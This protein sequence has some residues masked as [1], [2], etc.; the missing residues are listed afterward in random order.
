M[1]TSA[2]A[3]RSIQ[4]SR[5]ANNQFIMQRAIS[6]FT[7]LYPV[8]TIAVSGL[9]LAN[10][11][12][13]VWF[14][15]YIVVALGFVMLNMGLTLSVKDFNS[16]G[17]MPGSVAV[18]FILHYTIMPLSGWFVAHWLKLDPQF[19]VGLILVASCPC[20]TASNL[21][22]Y[23]ARGNLALSVCLTMIS[24]MLAFVMTPLWCQ[25]LAGQYV[26]VSALAMSISTLKMV[27]V[28]VLGGVI[29][30]WSAPKVVARVVPWGQFL[31]V[32]TFLF[33]TGSI[34]AKDAEAVKANAGVLAA[35]ALLLHVLGFGLGYGAARLLGYPLNIARTLSI[36]VGMQNGGLA[37][38]LARNNISS[39]SLA[40]VP[41]VFSA[42][43]QTLVGSVIATWWRLHPVEESSE[44]K[45]T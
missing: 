45:N 4:E 43:I 13:L 23:L 26:P 6:W 35:A 42:L 27:V 31:A 12:L 33:V 36:E 21:M 19:A 7:N 37:A 1:G 41:A 5:T 30:N 2:Q 25:K 32:L 16:V 10:P 17:K 28:P 39:M 44:T 40:A 22:T 20:G 9:A 18:G 11:A 29:L 34:V 3:G 38:A 24:T 14:N 15:P 8:W